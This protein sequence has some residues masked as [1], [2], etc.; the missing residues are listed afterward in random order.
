MDTTQPYPR[1]AFDDNADEVLLM[2][3]VGP[4]AADRGGRPDRS[5][6]MELVA[7]PSVSFSSELQDL[8]RSRLRSAALA[9][10]GVYLVLLVWNLAYGGRGVLVVPVTMGMRAALA[11]AVFGVLSGRRVALSLEALR[12]VELLLFGGITALLVVAQYLADVEFVRRGDAVL[13]VAYEKNG[14]LQMVFVMTLYGVLIPNRP[15]RTARVVLTLLLG[16][17]VVLILAL[18]GRASDALHELASTHTLAIN[19]AIYLCLGAAVAI[20]VAYV[21]NRLGAELREAKR[22]GQYRLGE[23]LGSGGMGDVFLAEHQLLKR[24]CALKTINRS[25]QANPI[26]QQRFEREVR[27]AAR[28]SHPNT[29]AIYD[30]GHTPDGTFYYV[31]EY[32]PGLSLDDLVRQFGPLPPG[33]AVYL[34][35][36]VCGGLA[37]AHGAGLIHRD[38]KPANV[39]VA[40]LGGQCDVAKVLDFGL[41]KQADEAPD[42]GLTG[43]AVVSGT[44]QFMA[45]EQARGLHDLD[46]RADQYAV[47]GV[48]YYALTGRPP[49][50]GGGAMELMIQHARDPVPPPSRFNAAIPAD[51]EAVVLRTLEKDPDARYAD[52]RELSRALGA[53]ACAADWDADRAEAWWRDQAAAR[54]HLETPAVS[55]SVPV[56]GGLSVP[57]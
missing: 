50:V 29:I 40:I 18:A 17:L 4:E 5:V 1:P 3:T 25:M 42:E 9:F 46:A 43:E 51:L 20:Y 6:H 37:E 16:P 8:L 34:L 24:A 47:G 27:S 22:L 14:I 11:V 56:P 53:C 7:G 21:L 12:A 39:F 49:F 23:R 28:L 54:T 26:A 45:P 32:L 57:R 35:R 41:V 36:Q 48:L 2:P 33:R 30:Y 31:M 19:N 38:L 15:D 55:G 13:L 10:A 52:V 44:P